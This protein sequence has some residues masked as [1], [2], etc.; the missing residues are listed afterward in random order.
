MRGTMHPTM[1]VKKEL[2][3]KHGMFDIN[4]KMA[5]DYDFLC[6]I[7]GEKNIFI[8]YPLC[9]F[10][11]NGVSTN[12]YL[13]AMKESYAQYRKYYGWSFKQLVWG[14]RLTLLHYLLNSGFG[15]WLYAK[16]VKMGKENW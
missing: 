6:R 16:K 5:M 2:Y 14:W 8:D 15:K 1:Y 12:K 7:A 11:P 10:D 3:T 4:L 9:T 13:D